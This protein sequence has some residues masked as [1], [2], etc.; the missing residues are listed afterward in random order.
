[1]LVTIKSNF[2]EDVHSL[3]KENARLKRILE[4][5]KL[6]DIAKGILMKN[7]GLSEDEAYR[8]MQKFSMDKRKKMSEIAEALII[9]EEVLKA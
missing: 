4:E 2:S 6:I 3:K 7:E 9:T 8:R 5:R 1:M